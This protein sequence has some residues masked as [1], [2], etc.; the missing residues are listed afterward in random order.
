PVELLD[1]KLHA[2]IAGRPLEA[3]EDRHRGERRLL[4][5]GVDP[6]HREAHASLELL[7]VAPGHCDHIV[8]GEGDGILH[9]RPPFSGGDITSGSFR[10]AGDRATGAVTASRRPRTGERTGK[11]RPSRG[12]RTPRALPETET[13]A[14]RSSCRGVAWPDRGSPR[15][16]PRGGRDCPRGSRDGWPRAPRGARVW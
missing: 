7:A 10:L 6:I 12:I 1:G 8:V 11:R 16:G 2:R 15:D 13:T 3:G 14:R 5:V 4:P 9:G